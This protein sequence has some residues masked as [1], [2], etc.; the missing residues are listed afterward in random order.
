MAEPLTLPDRTMSR[1]EFF[2]W[3]AQQ[4]HGRFERIGGRVV[5][6]SPE[7]I[8]HVRTKTAVWAALR[9]AIA[10]AGADCEAL[11]DGVTVSVDADT[12]YEPDVLV[13]C[14]E[15]AGD[16][17]VA[18]PNPVVVVEVVSPSSKAVDTGAKFMDY[19]RLVSIRHYLILRTDQRMVV[20]HRRRDDGVIESRLLGN[21]PLALDPLGIVVQAENFFARGPA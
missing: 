18:A 21:G 5:A 11:G 20:H 17:A 3:A 12:D 1:E 4:S 19:F 14:G 10:A 16:D 9:D 2:A 15:R 6:M 8:G 7:R 13:N